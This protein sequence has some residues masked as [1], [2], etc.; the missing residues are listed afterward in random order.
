MMNV[1]NSIDKQPP[2]LTSA[3][4]VEQ[5]KTKT[6]SIMNYSTH[7][8]ESQHIQYDGIHFP[9]IS[10][11]IWT[12]CGC[13]STQLSVT[14]P[15][16]RTIKNEMCANGFL[17]L[18]QLFEMV[19]CNN[20]QKSGWNYDYLLSISCSSLKHDND[21]MHLHTTFQELVNWFHIRFICLIFPS[22]LI[23]TIA[24]NKTTLV[25][26]QGILHWTTSR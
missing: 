1:S 4:T 14:Q 17:L 23:K 8:V 19:L 26:N 11:S 6:K 24:F 20:C 15:N 16:N 10:L 7:I 25:R 9:K 21:T 12:W 13:A 2:N 18:L 3:Q 22:N 5:V